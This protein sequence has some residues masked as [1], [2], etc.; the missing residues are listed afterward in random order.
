M[1][2]DY[3]NRYCYICLKFSQIIDYFIR[4]W[5]FMISK[6]VYVYIY[7]G[8]HDVLWNKILNINIY[9]SCSQTCDVSMIMI[10][11]MVDEHNFMTLTK[12]FH[13]DA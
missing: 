9:D 10:M 2:I 7:G 6:H 5:I 1:I 12:R 13:G 11:C 8:M 4:K 3:F